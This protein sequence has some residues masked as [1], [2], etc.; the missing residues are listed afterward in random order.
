[1]ARQ[2]PNKAAGDRTKS[3]SRFLD[4][5]A[6][7]RLANIK[8]VARAVVE[9][10]ISGL[11][12]SPYKGFSVEFAEYRE[13]VQGDDL[14]HF[15]WKVYART[16]KE[17]IRLYQEETN[18]RVHVLLDCSASMN[19]G[20]G[21]LTKFDYGAFLA[22][23]LAYL[24]IRQQ[25]SCGL[26]IFDTEIRQN[27]PPRS[28][29]LHLKNMLTALE[30]TKPTEKTSIAETLHKL[31]ETIVKRGL[32]V[33]VSDLFDDPEA[34]MK[35]LHHFRH[36]RHE[37]ILFHVM[38]PAEIEFPFEEMTE[39]MDMETGERLNVNPISVR[40]EY[41]K[42]VNDFIS[43]FKLEC[44]KSNIE[45]LLCNTEIPFEVLLARYLA[46]RANLS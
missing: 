41:L 31:A 23:S 14:K 44:S 12:R 20:S 40:E 26:T 34:I 7:A 39:F 15:D 22:A 30:G 46:K 3:P 36:K 18:L 9:G 24:A 17:Y 8:L 5:A 28:N 16:E 45:Y 2:A 37:V 27:I 11:H 42:K 38:D 25:D 10:F 1:M 29:P 6:L 21:A 19:F 13:Y 35:G 33:L 43:R 4:P 32:I